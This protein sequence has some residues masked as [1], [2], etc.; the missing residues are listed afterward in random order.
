MDLGTHIGQE[1]KSCSHS[2]VRQ[3]RLTLLVGNKLRD[4]P[5]E[6]DLNTIEWKLFRPHTLTA[7]FIPVLT[8]SAL[9]SK[10]T[11]HLQA[12]LLIAMLAASTLIQAATNV[13]NEYF[14]YAQGLDTA[15]SVGIAGA[16]TQEAIQLNVILRSA[17]WMMI[18]VT[19]LGGFI[20]AHS[21]WWLA[22]IGA[23]SMLVGDLYT[24]GPYPIAATSLG[25]IFAGGFMGSGI[26]LLSCFI[27]QG[28]I[29]T[30]DARISIPSAILIAAILTSN[31]I[32]D[33]DGDRNNSQH[34][35]AIILGHKRAVLLL[36][37][38][39]A[40]AN[41]CV[42]APVIAGTLSPWTLLVV[43]SLLPSVAAIQIFRAGWQTSADDAWDEASSS[44][45]HLLRIAAFGR[46]AV[47]RLILMDCLFSSCTF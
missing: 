30:Y 18:L 9:A 14:D 39:P 7:S 19:L 21:S 46:L 33:L 8:G 26:I 10:T 6:R 24:G 13:F 15:E 11:G 16:I 40:A 12:G 41:L 45:E 17:V 27:Q 5:I 37:C 1:R 43:G 31:N 25:E 2:G 42:V 32:R 47:G 44:D 20:C 4:V 3:T 23:I 35:L 36:A 38:S 29:N 34:T 28:F 22:L